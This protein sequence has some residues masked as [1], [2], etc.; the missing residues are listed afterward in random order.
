MMPLS[1]VSRSLTLKDGKNKAWEKTPG[2]RSFQV[3]SPM[4]TTRLPAWTQES[5]E[6]EEERP[7]KD[8]SEFPTVHSKAQQ[9]IQQLFILQDLP[10]STRK[11]SLTTILHPDLLL[12]API[13]GSASPKTL[14]LSWLFCFSWV[15]LAFSQSM[16]G[17]GLDPLLSPPHFVR[18]P[19]PQLFISPMPLKQELP[20][21]K[22]NTPCRLAT[23]GHSLHL[24]SLH[25]GLWSLSPSCTS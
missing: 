9:F 24:Y 8:L 4:K 6:E 25:A 3:S 21:S 17:Q 15:H 11:L 14:A 10:F 16:S 13:K 23:P 5:G 12:L 2:K 1:T 19:D 22:T 18:I 7:F 20:K